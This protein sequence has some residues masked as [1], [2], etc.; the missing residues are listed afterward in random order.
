MVLHRPVEL[1]AATRQLD[2]LQIEAQ[3]RPG[4]CWRG[5]VSFLSLEEQRF[6]PSHFQWPVEG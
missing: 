4:P 3:P 6:L 5:R 2:S 1:A